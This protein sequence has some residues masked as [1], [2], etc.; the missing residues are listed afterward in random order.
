VLAQRD[1]PSISLAELKFFRI[2]SRNLQNV[3]TTPIGVYASL[4]SVNLSASA[5]G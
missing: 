4:N 1:L 2:Y 5:R 3:N